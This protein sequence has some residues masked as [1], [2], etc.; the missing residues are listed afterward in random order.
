M[1]EKLMKLMN[2]GQ[3]VLLVGPPGVAKSARVE[4]VAKELGRRCVVTR[5]SLCERIDFGGCLIPDVNAGIT[6]TLPLELLA[7]LR[8]TKTPTVLFLD[9]LGQA[10]IDVQSALMRLFDPGE[11]SPQVLIWGAT[12]RPGDKAGVT[13]L[14]EPLRSRFNLAFA[15]AS[16]GCDEKPEGA[17]FLGTWK[18]EVE[19]WGEWALDNGACPEVV[20][21]HRST[22]GRTLYAWKPCADPAVRMADFRGWA[23]VINLWNAGLRD[24]STVGAAVGKPA[25]A[26]FLAFARLAD[27]LPTPDQVFMDPHGAPVPDEPSALYLVAT[28]LAAAVTQQHADAFCTYIDRMNRVFAALAGRDAYRKLG[29]K[30][31]GSKGWCRWFVKNQELFTAGAK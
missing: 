30:L 28:M 9:D 15:I 18:D 29:A 4:Y 2:A 7:D 16:P 24:L 11:L 6:R 3:K 19:A 22:V 25:A 27:D 8:T 1:H 12:N 5:A 13:A 21:W 14:C 26:E 10:P 31:S 17:T 20:A 23:T